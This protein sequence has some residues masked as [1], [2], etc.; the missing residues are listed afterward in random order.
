MRESYIPQ[1]LDE[2]ERYIIFTPD[3][4]FIVAGSLLLCTVIA[5]F[6][7]GLGLAAFGFWAIRKFK[8]GSSLHR[9]KWA[10]YWLLPA[11]LLRLKATP[12]S[13]LRHLAG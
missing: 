11:D 8:K 4:L 1:Y 2:P 10:A 13:Y 9:M 12:P 6:A 3:E 5:N 7:I